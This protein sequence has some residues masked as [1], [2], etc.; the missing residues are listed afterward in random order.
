[1]ISDE[2]GTGSLVFNT[3]PT[4]VNANLVN[5][6]SIS[7]AGN[8]TVDN[9]FVANVGTITTLTA[10][11]LVAGSS[12]FAL[13]NGTATTI[14]F[15]GAATTLN[16]GGNN[17]NVNFGSST[18]QITAA[19]VTATNFIGTVSNPSLPS[20]RVYGS[21]SSAIASGT[22]VASANGTIVDYNQ[23][24]YYN[25]T[26][27]FFTAPRAGLYH[28]YATIRVGT[29]NGMNQAS[30]QK[31]SSNTGSNVIA[32]WETDTNTGTATHFSMTGYA[33]CA[34]GDTIRLYIVTGNVNFDANDSWG[35]TYIG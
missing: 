34:A 8:L 1:V 4:I 22:T 21:S 17:V 13:L 24:S 23:G 29:N 28:C 35:V 15:G 2:T 14:N 20:F 12:S 11:S 26:T 10:T 27:G 7:V 5:P 32:F 18:G 31:N 25:N 33:K 6:S 3:G 9:T 16:V 30:I 19:N